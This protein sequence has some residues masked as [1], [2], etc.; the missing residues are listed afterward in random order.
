MATSFNCELDECF[1]LYF[2]FVAYFAPDFKTLP[3]TPYNRTGSSNLS[4]LAQ[5]PTKSNR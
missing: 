2:C 1:F 3:Q 5:K 4:V